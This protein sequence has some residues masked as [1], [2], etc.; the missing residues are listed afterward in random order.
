MLTV[1][2]GRENRLAWLASYEFEHFAKFVYAFRAVPE[3]KAAF[4]HFLKL[5]GVSLRLYVV[6][7]GDNT[8]TVRIAFRLEVF[9]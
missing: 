9:G 1:L 2:A 5:A 3:F 6:G 8:S 7:L 4:N